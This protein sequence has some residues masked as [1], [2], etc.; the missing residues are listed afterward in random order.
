MPFGSTV[1]LI[2]SVAD[3]GEIVTDRLFD[4]LWGVGVDASVT[5]MLTVFVPT[6]MVVPLIRPEAGS[7]LNPLGNPVA[8]QV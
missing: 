2:S 5:V 7:I 1:V 3:A 6:T 8:A 4:T